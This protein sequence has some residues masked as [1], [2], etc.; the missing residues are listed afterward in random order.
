M[1]DG[2][3]PDAEALA[4]F[5]E[6]WASVKADV[7]ARLEAF[8]DERVA[9]AAA[10]G[11]DPGA[12]MA[13]TRALALRGGKRFR[14]ALLALAYQGFGGAGG[15]AAVGPAGVALELLQTYFLIH[16]DWM[17]DD[18]VRRG[19]PSV[20]AVLRARFG[21]RARGDATAILAGDYA[22][23]LA[24]EVL[25]QCEAPP[26][27]VLAAARV[28]AETQE[29]VCFGQVL[30]LGG[31]AADVELV[32]DL[33]TASYTV[34]GPMAMGAAL[35]SAPPAAFQ[36]I[37]RFARPVGVA[38]QIR[39]DLLGT[40]GASE[41]TG[42]PIGNDLRQGKRTAVIAEAPDDA[43]TRALMA[44]AF[45]RAD[46]SEGDVLAL[47]HHLA[48]CGARARAEARLDRLVADGLAALDGLAVTPSARLALRGAVLALAR[49]DR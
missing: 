18:D 23:A 5:H 46:A 27:A 6:F 20:H 32:H 45:G 36:A 13:A 40:F 14:P 48:S 19:G 12:V 42:K 39:D 4:S 30:D 24:N 34:R 17:D 44:A 25:L 2:A 10:L 43:D 41:A 28:M 16:D 49:R 29:D 3:P 15:M 8:L 7:D 35:A 1:H 38:F 26:A 31:R 21:S 22:A 11:S 33:K 9:R 37:A 47:T